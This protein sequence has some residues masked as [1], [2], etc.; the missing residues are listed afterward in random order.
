MARLPEPGGDSGQWG[1][2]LNDYLTV[3]HATDGSLKSDTV[4]TGT[5]QNNSITAAKLATTSAPSNGQALTYTTGA[6]EWT[7]PVSTAH[8]HDAA[9]ITSGTL[10]SAQLPT[11]TESTQGAVQLASV[12]EVTTGTDTTKA[13]T[14]AG[15]AA[16]VNAVAH[17]VLFVDALADIPPGTPGDTLVI[18][19]AA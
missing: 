13:V 5:I 2:V 12:S 18:V 14:P 6:L 7:T 4:T 1:E 17:P 19:R 10:A 3:V 9:D 15:V 11:A 8:T 16:A